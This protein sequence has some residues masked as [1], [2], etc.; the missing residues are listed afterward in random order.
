MGVTCCHLS[1]L[2]LEGEVISERLISWCKIGGSVHLV[3]RMLFCNVIHLSNE[4]LRSSKFL[5]VQFSPSSFPV[6]K[7]GKDD[8]LSIGQGRGT[9]ELRL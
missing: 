4:N 5:N 9:A 8:D 2:N 1:V 3:C 6:N 7:F